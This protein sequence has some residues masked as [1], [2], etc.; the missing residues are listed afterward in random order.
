MRIHSSLTH[1]SNKNYYQQ[2]RGSLGSEIAW[3]CCLIEGIAARFGA[4]LALRRNGH[5]FSCDWRF[6]AMFGAVGLRGLGGVL[7][8]LGLSLGL[9]ASC[10][11]SGLG[12]LFTSW[13]G[14]GSGALRGGI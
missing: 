11:A 9:G 14:L 7:A 10:D 5:P 2:Y 4:R 1:H 8:C 3:R 12:V 6:G 13:A